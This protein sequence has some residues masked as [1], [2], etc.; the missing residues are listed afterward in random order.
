[1]YNLKV[2]GGV[3]GRCSTTNFR[4]VCLGNK[5]RKKNKEVITIKVGSLITLEREENGNYWEGG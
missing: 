3:G 4:D 2:C 1:M 5:T